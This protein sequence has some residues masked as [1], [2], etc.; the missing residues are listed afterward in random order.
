MTRVLQFSPRGYVPGGHV[1]SMSGEAHIHRLVYDTERIQVDEDSW[2]PFF[3]KNRWYSTQANEPSILSGNFWSVD[4]PKVWGELRIALELANRI[5]NALIKDKHIFLQTVLFGK[6]AYWERARQ[7]FFPEQPPAPAP[8]TTVLLSYPFYKRRFTQRYPNLPCNMDAV[9]NLT[10]EQY[11]D[12]IYLLASQQDWALVSYKHE[13]RGREAGRTY[14]SEGN[15][16]FLNVHPIRALIKNEITLAERLML[17]YYIANT[18]LHEFAHALISSRTLDDDSHLNRLRTNEYAY[19]EPF[20]DFGPQ[21]EMGYFMETTVFGGPLRHII[22]DGPGG[23]LIA[24]HRVTWPFLTHGR[25]LGLAIPEHPAISEGVEDRL[26]LIP[27]FWYSGILSEDFWQGDLTPRKSDSFFYITDC[28]RSR[29]PHQPGVKMWKYRRTPVIEGDPPR[30][31]KGVAETIANWEL[32]E[33][34]WNQSR[35]GWYDEE[36]AIWTK[37]PWGQVLYRAQINMFSK[38]MKTPLD[39]RDIYVCVYNA[40]VL[41][42]AVAWSRGREEYIASVITPTNWVFHAIGLLM[43]ACLPLRSNKLRREQPERNVKIH[44]LIPSSTTYPKITR[45][46]AQT[47]DKDWIPEKCWESVYC[48]PLGGTGYGSVYEKGSFNHLSYL[49]LVQTLLKYFADNNILVS[50]PWLDEILRVEDKIRTYR[51]N[52]ASAG[53]S[54]D[55][56]STWAAEAWDFQIPEYDPVATSQWSDVIIAWGSV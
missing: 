56:D 11:R 47:V 45:R 25:M 54:V 53:G 24:P 27:S 5:L 31:N 42:A 8:N 2:F 13:T 23:V 4:D 46:L 7:Q 9:L 55:P 16:I 20:V 30:I 33:S 22:H 12:K 29:T 39:Q 17:V 34:L 44:V 3:K 32:R 51:S 41:S 40:M 15:M 38:Q 48:N 21:A 37:S 18:V 50:T 10:E 43:F 14:T 36:K 1:Y 52:A 28:F 49:D 19:N 6:L 26:T 35:A